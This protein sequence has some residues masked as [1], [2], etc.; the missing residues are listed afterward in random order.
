MNRQEF[1]AAIEEKLEGMPDE[2]VSSSLDYYEEMINE[3]IDDGMSEEEAIRDMG[4]VD[5]ITARIFA[6]QP[7][8]LVLRDNIRDKIKPSRAL[9]VWEIV[10][11]VLGSP[12]WISLLAAGLAV[13]V[14]LTAVALSVYAALWC[15]ILALWL[16]VF[17]L[18]IAAVAGIGW[19][20]AAPF[21]GK[22]MLS[23]LTAG[24]GLLC[25][26]AGILMFFIALLATKGLAKATEFCWNA[27]FGKRNR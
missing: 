17:A 5:D 25:A 20:I 6:E 13:V 1:L 7:L 12:L 15:V 14:A 19:A 10:L 21:A 16:C 26:G 18:G 22:P 11:I 9:K 27:V 3:R 23:L 8:A 4:S 24:G 2:D